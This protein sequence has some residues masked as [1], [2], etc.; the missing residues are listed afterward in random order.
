MR[1]CEWVGGCVG[2]R[3]YG[4]VGLAY[5]HSERRVWHILFVDKTSGPK[6]EDVCLERFL[7]ILDLMD[8]HSE[9]GKKK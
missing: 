1:V 4:I 8:R 6:S 5:Q 2:G 7:G 9:T 3:V